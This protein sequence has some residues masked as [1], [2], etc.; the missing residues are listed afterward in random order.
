MILLHGK[1]SKQS[2]LKMKQDCFDYDTKN[3]NGNLR[4]R[5]IFMGIPLEEGFVCVEGN[6]EGFFIEGKQASLSSANYF[7]KTC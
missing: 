6:T 2:L 5:F 1:I 4:E 7:L 3:N